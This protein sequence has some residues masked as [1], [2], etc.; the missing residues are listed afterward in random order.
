M[1]RLPMFCPK[2]ATPME[3]GG[4]EYR[5][6]R[7]DMRLSQ[8]MQSALTAD[9]LDPG[10]QAP[11]RPLGYRLGGTWF[12]PRDATRMEIA[13]GVIGCPQ[14]GRSLN[15]HVYALVELHPH[16]DATGRLT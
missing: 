6:T 1:A 3:V 12:C 15:A 9:F 2:S 7:G 16:I 4:P 10:D 8:A 11:P 13:D 14:C 5:C